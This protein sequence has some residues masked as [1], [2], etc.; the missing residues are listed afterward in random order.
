[1]AEW[2]S[3][4][5]EDKQED[6]G[7]RAEECPRFTDRPFRLLRGKNNA[8]HVQKSKT[9]TER[10][11]RREKTK[12]YCVEEQNRTKKKEK[13]KQHERRYNHHRRSSGQVTSRSLQQQEGQK[14]VLHS[15]VC[16][17]EAYLQHILPGGD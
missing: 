4:I 12:V 8:V 10:L 6:G 5:E 7:M 11:D 2:E 17:A 9:Q 15:A 13:K 3:G 1:M 16:Q 14:V